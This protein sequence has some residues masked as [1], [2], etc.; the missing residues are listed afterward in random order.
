MA[1]KENLLDEAT[2]E[3]LKPVHADECFYLFDPWLYNPLISENDILM[4][5]MLVRYWTN[6]AKYGDPSPSGMS[7]YP[8]WWT[9]SSEKV[10][11]N[12]SC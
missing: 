3:A 1:G 8:K 5:K 9:Y 10:S 12:K 4:S 11:M 6:F 7:E 2:Q